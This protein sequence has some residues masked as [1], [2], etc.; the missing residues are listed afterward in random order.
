MALEGKFGRRQRIAAQR[1]EAYKLYRQRKAE[2]AIQEKAARAKRRAES[3]IWQRIEARKKKQ[4]EKAQERA[5]ERAE[6]RRARPKAPKPGS[7]EYWRQRY[8][9]EA[10]KSKATPRKAPYVRPQPRKPSAYMHPASEPQA[11]ALRRYLSQFQ[12]G[13]RTPAPTPRTYFTMG[14]AGLG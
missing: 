11:G 7:K 6:R 4:R 5:E 2:R 10:A 14:L 1:R 9:E 8:K 13:R 12:P 3:P